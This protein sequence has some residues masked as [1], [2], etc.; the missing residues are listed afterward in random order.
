MKDLDTIIETAFRKNA[1]DIHLRDGAKARIR[2]D[3]SLAEFPDLPTVKMQSLVDEIFD[4]LTEDE[5][6]AM[7]ALRKAGKDM[8]C[9]FSNISGIR[10]RANIYKTQGGLCA[11]LRIIRPDRLSAGEIGL[12]FSV[13]DVCN[14]KSGLFLITGANGMGKSTTIAAL[15]DIMNSTR[16]VHILTIENPIEH[17]FKSRKALITQR[18]VGTHTPDFYSALRSSVRENPDVIIVGELRDLETTRTAIELAETGHLVIASLHTRTAIST[19]DRLIGQFPSAEQQQIRMM[20]SE[21]L[22]GVLSQTLLVRK[23]GG[24]VAA[25]EVLIATPAVRNLIREQKIPQ[26]KSLMQTGKNIGMFTLDDSLLGLAESG[27]VSA[28]EALSK[29]Q[30][31]DELAARINA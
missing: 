11:A 30:S 3:N 12:P 24:L 5:R 1:S 2:I 4:Y 16:Q 29:S 28:E 26:I 17:V 9:A 23:S 10:L 8:D 22:I 13:T 21:S 20:I 19:I 25:F 31:R 14:K 18:E 27:T 7:L 15:I 6:N